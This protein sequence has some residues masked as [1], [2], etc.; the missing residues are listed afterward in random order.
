MR[1]PQT[2]GDAAS[3][4]V[5]QRWRPRIRTILLLGNVVVLCLPLSGIWILRLY[6]S[7]LIRQTESELIAQAAVVGAAFK[8]AW[9]A[10]ATPDA[11][12]AQ[13]LSRAQPPSGYPAQPDGWR[14]HAAELD[15]A[16]DPILPAPEP[17]LPP[18]KPA[19]PLAIRAGEQLQ[20]VLRDAQRTT[21]AG[22]RIL[23]AGGI[24][25]STTRDELGLCL[26]HQEEVAAAL[27]G[28]ATSRL[29]RRAPSTYDGSIFPS[30][31]RG[32]SVRV[33]VAAPI[34]ERDRVLGAVLVSRTARSI[35]QALYGKRYHLAGL[36]ALLIAAIVSL[37]WFT[38]WT[39]SRP[40]Q[41]V[42]E[43]ARQAA[44]GNRA[45]I[46]PLPHRFTRE[47]ADLS[48][49]LITMARSLEERS[50]YIRA[51]AL[52][53]SHEFKT[54][55]TSIRGAVEILKDHFA[56][57]SAAERE[58]FLDNI[59][60]DAERLDR[61][62]RRLLDLARADVLRPAGDERTELGEL[63]CAT[64]E[65]YRADGLRLSLQNP[66][67]AVAVTV[68]RESLETVLRNLLDNVRQHAGPAAEAS[69]VWGED[70]RRAFI[71]VADM[72]IGV[73]PG[74]AVRIFDRFYTTARGEGGT[75]LGLPIARSRLAAYGGTIELMP[76][77]A[78]AAFEITLP[79]APEQ[80]PP[81][82]C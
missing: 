78:G 55:L 63:I 73:T 26:A 16:D 75:G 4:A 56:E 66:G 53:V 80:R 36:A 2:A 10:A 42:T 81:D 22:I 59:A 61:L 79:L 8:A 7:A 52:E 19:E 67:K 62:V 6:E 65:P 37:A 35:D 24:V 45:A 68:G 82:R 40:I 1:N 54:P 57:M 33:F 39:I 76:S 15:L 43:Q 46:V 38:A 21:L 30:L 44:G 5:R 14:P 71:R 60:G 47:A 25:V 77:A 50:D 20:P 29:R 9:L 17:A 41:S 23:D 58:R 64:A 3:D 13:P 18:Q 72:G 48:A 49:S 31:S 69:I 12:G 70:D 74:N 34:M 32:G 11:L 51:F 27:A 28:S